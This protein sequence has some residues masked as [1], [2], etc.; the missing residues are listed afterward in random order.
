M[1][2]WKIK[3]IHIGNRFGV[4]VIYSPARAKKA[5]NI[6]QAAA[7]RNVF[8]NIGRCDYESSSMSL[9]QG[10]L[11]TG[12]STTIRHIIGSLL[13]HTRVGHAKRTQRNYLEVQDDV[14]RHFNK[15]TRLEFYCWP[16][17]T[18]PLILYA[19]GLL[20]AVSWN[21]SVFAL[22]QTMPEAQIAKI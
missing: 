19:Q 15:T 2:Y 17:R 3:A 8:R 6:T 9:V 10:H 13:H 21:R 16:L 11:C 20:P 1:E 12:K 7:V 22:S 5:L 4:R 18:Q 14:W